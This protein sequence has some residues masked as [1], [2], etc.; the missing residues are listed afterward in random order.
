MRGMQKGEKMKRIIVFTICFM[1]SG[2]AT[3]PA[4]TVKKHTL[5]IKPEIS[6]FR[7]R[8]PNVMEEEGMMYGLALSYA[9]HNNWMLKTE[10]RGSLGKVDY[11]GHGCRREQNGTSDDITDYILEF[12]QLGGYDFCALEATSITPYFGVG[13][14]YLNDDGAGKF[15][16]TG[17]DLCERESNYLYSPIGIEISTALNKGWS[18]GTNFEYDYF[19]WGEQKTRLTDKVGYSTNLKNEQEKGYGCRGSIELRKRSEKLD[20]A[21]GPFVRYWSIRVSKR[22]G[23]TKGGVAKTGVEPKNNTIEIGGQ[24]S[25]RF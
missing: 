25:I 14:R 12:R 23:Y 20:F 15:T 11:S 18:I 19:W 8:E 3:I 1:L 9:Y 6:Y 4:E 13:Y 7:Y 21:I 5:D 2:V 16:S 10:A 17:I 24:L 22:S